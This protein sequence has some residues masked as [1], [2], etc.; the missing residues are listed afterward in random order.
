MVPL[1]ELSGG[2]PLDWEPHQEQAFNQMKALL[3]HHCFNVYIDLHFLFD[4]YTDTI[5]DQFGTNII[6]ANMLV[7]KEYFYEQHSEKKGRILI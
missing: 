6:L 4:I 2:N 3:M 1:L 7:L 5:N